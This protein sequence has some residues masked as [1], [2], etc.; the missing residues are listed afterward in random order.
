MNT[1]DID[2]TTTAIAKFCEQYDIYVIT[3]ISKK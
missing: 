1:L 3:N 2:L